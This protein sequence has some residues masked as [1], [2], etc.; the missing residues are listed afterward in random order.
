MSWIPIQLWVR[1]LSPPSDGGFRDSYP[2]PLCE[3]VHTSAMHKKQFPE[4]RWKSVTFTAAFF[5]VRS[6]HRD[7][8]KGVVP[9]K[10]ELCAKLSIII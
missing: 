8:V 2:A 7:Y 9:R 3:K 5:V 1:N 10:R 4:L 6:F